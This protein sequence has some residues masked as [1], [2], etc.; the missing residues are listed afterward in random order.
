MIVQMAAKPNEVIEIR[1]M[2]YSDALAYLELTREQHNS[3]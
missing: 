1:G 3:K 2:R